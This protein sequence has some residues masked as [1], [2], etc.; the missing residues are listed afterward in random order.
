MLYAQSPAG[1]L[2]TFIVS[3]VVTVVL[4]SVIAHSRLLLWEG[5]MLAVTLGRVLLVWWYR[6]RQPPEEALPL[7]GQRFLLGAGLAGISWGLSAVLCF[8]SGALEY[9]F[10][11][12]FVLCGMAVGATTTFASEM[13][14]FLAFFLPTTIPITLRLF[15]EGSGIY[16]TLGSLALLFIGIL[17]MLARHLHLSFVES[18][19]LRFENLDLVEKLTRARDRAEEASRIKS[20]FLANMSH[21]IRTPMNGVL[22]MTE[23]LL[24]QP[25]PQQAHHYA[26]QAHVSARALLILI[27]DILDLSKIE[28]GKVAL[29][30]I[31]FDPHQVVRDMYALFTAE[32]HKKGLQFLVDIPAAVPHTLYG[33]PYRLR[34]VLTNLVAN[35]LKFTPSG[36]VRLRV[37]VRDT[38][39]PDACLLSCTVEDTGIGVS[40]EVQ[41]RLFQPF[42]QGDGSMTRRYGGTGLGLAISKQLVEM[43]GGDIGVRST[44]GQGAAFWFTVPFTT[45]PQALPGHTVIPAGPRA[46]SATV[47]TRPA[48]VLLVEDN[49]INQEITRAM[50]EFLG[51]QVEIVDTGTAALAAF[52][53]TSYEIVLMDCQMPDMDGR[54]ATQIMRRQEAVGRHTPII[55]VTAHSMVEDRARCLAAGMDDYLSKPFSQEELEQMMTRWVSSG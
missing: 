17:I 41:A 1:M 15:V 20:Q 4:W 18:L 25:L 48:R 2:A 39:A 8:P 12:T 52:G 9:E 23:L 7:W 27:N 33:D 14:T 46:P 21:E 19:R 37:Q 26:T 36:T 3:A 6:R 55:A 5:I 30:H 51:Y 35:A 47:G 13:R 50:L 44:L 22:G 53:Q 54:E 16:V 10:F 49:P 32:A 42:T 11:L 38:P 28:A 34:Q 29:E 24:D 43:M 31:V 45:T 40:E